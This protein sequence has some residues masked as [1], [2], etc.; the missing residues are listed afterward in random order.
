MLKATSLILALILFYFHLNSAPTIFFL[1][2]F[3]NCHECIKRVKPASTNCQLA[4]FS[5]CVVFSKKSLLA[6]GCGSG[7]IGVGIW[8]G[9]SIKR[10]SVP[11]KHQNPN[12]VNG[13][14]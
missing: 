10:K 8:L 3:Q 1:S 6:A 5:L 9:A 2:K 7:M 14:A 4:W 13:K 11:L 12:S